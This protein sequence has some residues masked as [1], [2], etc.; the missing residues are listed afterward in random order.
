MEAPPDGMIGLRSL[1]APGNVSIEG[2]ERRLV[3]LVYLVI[4]V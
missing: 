3:N 2:K 4:L 1:V